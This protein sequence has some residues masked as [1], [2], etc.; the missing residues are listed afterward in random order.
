[1][2]VCVEHQGSLCIPKM[3]MIRT[4]EWRMVAN[5]MRGVTSTNLFTARMAM[6][7]AKHAAYVYRRLNLW[8]A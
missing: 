7:M 2:K 5:E 1:M 8:M 4:Y 3:K 6:I